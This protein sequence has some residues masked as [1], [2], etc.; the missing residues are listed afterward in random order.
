MKTLKLDQFEKFKCTLDQINK[1][2]GGITRSGFRDVCDYLWK[3]GQYDQLAEVM[4]MANSGNI[5][6]EN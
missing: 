2:K 1:I 6:F 5:Q 3:N 4:K